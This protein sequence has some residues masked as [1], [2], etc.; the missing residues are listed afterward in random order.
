MRLFLVSFVS[1]LAAWPALAEL[2]PAEIGQA[3]PV[4]NQPS[5]VVFESRPPAAAADPIAYE[6]LDYGGR[7]VGEG[8]VAPS[9]TGAVTIP[10]TVPAGYFELSFPGTKQRF[11]LVAASEEPLDSFFGLDTAL[12]WLGPPPQR[13]SLIANLKRAGLGLSR[14]RLSWAAINPEKEQWDW[15]TS[16]GYDTVRRQYAENGVKILEMFH[17][18]PAWTKTAKDGVYPDSPIDTARSWKTIA[19]RWQSVWSALEVWNEPDIN[20]GGNLPADQYVPVVKSI[21]YALRSSGV[22]T[23]IGGGVVAYFNRPF[24]DLAARNGLLETSDFISFHYYG[25]PLGLEKHI[26]EFRGWL[27]QFGRESKP[28]WITEIGAPWEGAKNVR[29][30]MDLQAATALAFAMNTVEARACGIAVYFPFLYV[31]YSERD[32]KNYGMLDAKCFPLRPMAAYAQ[33][34]R[35]L[36]HSRYAGDLRLGDPA[37]QRS[38]VFETADGKAVAVLYTGSATSAPKVWIPFPVEKARGIDGRALEHVAGQEIS[39][40]DGLIYLETRKEDIEPWLVTDTEA[41]RLYEL[42][43]Q[44]DAPLPPASPIVLQ[45]LPDLA[46]L[47]AT[48]RGYN[49]PEGVAR[50]PMSLRVSN[51]S[52]QEREVLIHGPAIPETRISVGPQA[53]QVV[54][55]EVSPDELPSGGSDARLLEITA[56][57]PGL[58]A[59]PPAAVALIPSRGLQEHLSG[60]AYQFALPIGELH[61]WKKSTSGRMEFLASESAPWGFRATFG[62]GDRWAYPT[63]TLPQ[64]LDL[65]KTDSVLVRARCTGPASVR[66]MTWNEKDNVSFTTYSI[67]KA[68]GQWHV[69]R[70]PLETFLVPE[71]ENQRLGRQIKRF[72]IGL[73][74]KGKETL[75]EVSDLYFL[76]K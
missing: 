55:L 54:E 14:E 2:A 72:A 60:C 40:P 13:G 45:P 21:R 62:A 75:L 3:Y 51:L 42:G 65:D 39:I 17:N 49:L 71:Q 67:I 46:R 15:E 7:K 8:E 10:L 70:V 69:A 66:V 9:P 33:A 6:I 52:D 57:S 27:K 63:F 64:E 76:G 53:A 41:R 68:D 19:A 18:A 31:F 59:I 20:F 30:V 61:R 50:F 35:E 5:E 58:S 28:L 48:S 38:R 22:E 25:P 29:P 37:I 43:R 74:S 24:L 56:E 73:N 32:I 11:G 34:A 16:R 36:N 23:P 1:F 44:T 47:T 26:T 12:S 4:P